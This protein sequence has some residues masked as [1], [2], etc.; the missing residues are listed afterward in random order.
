MRRCKY[1][2]RESTLCPLN[3]SFEKATFIQCTSCRMTV[4][5]VDDCKLGKLE[6]YSPVTVDAYWKDIVD[7]TNRRLTL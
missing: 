6:C 1:F 7:E 2:Y 5:N 3:N 4:W